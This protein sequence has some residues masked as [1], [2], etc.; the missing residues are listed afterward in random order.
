MENFKKLEARDKE[1]ILKICDSVWDGDDYIPNVIDEWIIDPNGYF[2][3]LFDDEQLIAF[4]RLASQGDGNYWLEGLRKNHSLQMKGV[5]KKIANY[6]INIA[7]E[8]ECKSLKFSTYYDNIE[9]IA[10]NEK[11]GFA[12]IKEWS[13]LELDLKEK[14]LSPENGPTKDF[15]KPS[16]SQF[17]D[18][19]MKSDFLSAMGGYLCEGWKVFDCTETYLSKL[20]KKSYL[21][22][23]YSDNKIQAMA[24][25]IIDSDNNIFI[26]FF[27]F[28][29]DQECQS[30][31]NKI[32]SQAI[33]Q[34][35]HAVSIIVPTHENVDCL[36]KYGFKSWERKDDFLLFE[37]KGKL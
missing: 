23:I 7:M 14:D 12:K 31:M 34:N 22:A 5:G 1:Q 33:L 11:I 4:G 15:I 29:N 17:S 10:L 2:I 20:Y 6:L 36:E 32:I 35:S 8:K 19:I 25:T 27:E 24:S 28:A 37:Y 30:L 13:Y 26:T 9:S 16:F 18:F 3:G 21:L